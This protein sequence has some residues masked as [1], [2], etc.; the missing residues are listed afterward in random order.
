MFIEDAVQE[1]VSRTAERRR[2][3]NL[4]V[5]V[6][7]AAINR[8]ASVGAPMEFKLHA[9]GA[10]ARDVEEFSLKGDRINGLECDLILEDVVEVRCSKG[11]FAIQ[12]GLDHATFKR[13]VLFRL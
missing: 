4:R 10:A 3:Q 11:I 8:P 6:E 12:E 1:V 2:L 13:A 9:V 5:R 7:V